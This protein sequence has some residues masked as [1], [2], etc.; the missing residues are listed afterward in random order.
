MPCLILL[1][2]KCQSTPLY[3][4]I[5]P[6]NTF[7]GGRAVKIPWLFTILRNRTEQAHAII[8]HYETVKYCREGPP[9]WEQLVGHTGEAVPSKVCESVD[10]GIFRCM[11]LFNIFRKDTNKTFSVT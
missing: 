3:C 8:E 7:K 10:Q 2:F 9:L 4:I 11:T 6:V 1:F 5:V